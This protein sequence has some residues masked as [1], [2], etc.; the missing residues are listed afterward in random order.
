MTRR[1]VGGDDLQIDG[2]RYFDL[3]GFGER[4]SGLWS[5][6]LKPWR[7]KYRCPS[8]CRSSPPTRRRVT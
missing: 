6:F 5:R 7:S 8:I 2:Q 3:H 4:R 1:R